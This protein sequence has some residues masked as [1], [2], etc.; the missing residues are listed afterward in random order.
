M[1]ILGTYTN[2]KEFIEANFEPVEDKPGYVWLNKRNFE[3]IKI[4]TLEKSLKEWGAV[5]KVSEEELKGYTSGQKPI[6]VSIVQD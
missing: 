3:I 1:T 4:E 6:S 5:H 2:I